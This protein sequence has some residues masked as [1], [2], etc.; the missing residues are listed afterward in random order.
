MHLW[1]NRAENGEMFIHMTLIIRPALVILA[2]LSVLLPFTAAGSE[3]DLR[4]DTFLHIYQFDQPAGGTADYKPL[5]EFLSLDLT[6]VGGP[7]LS[8]HLSG[9]GRFDLGEKT[10]TDSSNTTF[11]SA[12]TR[13]QYADGTGLLKLGRFFLTE[14]IFMEALDGIHVRQSL[15]TIGLSLFSGSPNH[16]NGSVDKR[17]DLILG[18][19][20]FF[21]S[22]GRLELG[23]NY[24]TEN[25]DFPDEKREETGTDLWFHPTETLTLT[26]RTLYN[27]TTSSLASDYLSLS[28]R[29]N[30]NTEVVLNTYGYRYDDLFQASTNPVFTGT[31]INP[32]DE[33]R[34]IK[35]AVYWY[36][37]GRFNLSGSYSATDHRE[38]DP[39]DTHRSEVGM[40]INF[41]GNLQKV[42]LR[43]AIQKGDQQE[44]GY[45]EVRSFAMVKMGL[46]RFSLDALALLYEEKINGED[47]T[48][49]VTGSAGYAPTNRFFCSGDLRLIRSP[50]L[51]EDFSVLLRASY[52]F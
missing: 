23:L 29:P 19:R 2:L 8:F 24:L 7:D 41:T 17:G 20:T 4:S 46:F 22:P 33:V 52:G 44:N 25:G 11:S 9:A 47:Q 50:V 28:L 15:G 30:S 48:V 49:Q 13:Y 16:D 1:S 5:Y 43:A 26:G 12:Y 34:M 18:A 38:D 21:N 35:G 14:G 3:I 51:E 42:G 10:G 45:N 27:L 6:D 31:L 40:D 36:P 39:G 37:D 32:D